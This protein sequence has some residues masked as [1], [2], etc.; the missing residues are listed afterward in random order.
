MAELAEVISIVRDRIE[1][2]SDKAI[3]EQNTKSVLISPVLR[4]LG[5]DMEDLDEVQL[6]YK[7]RAMDNPVDYALFV[8]RSA[9]LFV[10]AKALGGNIADPKWS[11]QIMGYA[12]VAGVEWVCLTDGDSWH[13]YNSHV[14]VPVDQKLFRK[15]RIS[16]DGAAASET[17]SLLSKERMRE[18]L[19]DTLWKAHF[20][21]RQI[22]TALE[23]IFGPEPDAALVRLLR[24][25]APHLAPAEIRS[26]L[27][28]AQIRFDFPGPPTETST[29]VS[30]RTERSSS[31]QGP[32]DEPTP[33][34]KH[35]GEGTPWRHITLIDLIAES[36]IRPPLEL[37]KLYRGHLLSA[38]VE[39]DGQVSFQGKRYES[40]STAAGVARVSVAGPFPDRE[41]PQ[42]NGWTFWRFRDSD[43]ENRELDALRRR[44]YELGDSASAQK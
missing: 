38:R 16:E 17:L 28:R 18:N 1:Q 2:Y 3:G 22:K 31:K 25:H 33:A 11:G 23:R 24:K 44:L 21:D 4:A 14:V 30:A 39:A 6:E 9:R 37:S 19:I 35:R 43:G 40:L 13:I 42:T 29:P 10:E 41:Y 8:Q 32:T 5:W 12:V 26:G 36:L 15:V 20:V 34:R 27:V 7:R